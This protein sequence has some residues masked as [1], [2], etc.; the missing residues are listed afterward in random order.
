MHASVNATACLNNMNNN[1]DLSLQEDD[2]AMIRVLN[3]GNNH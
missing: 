2:S 3:M 1:N